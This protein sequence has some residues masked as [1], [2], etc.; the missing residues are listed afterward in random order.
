M[1]G[2]ARKVII[3]AAVDGLIL[4]PLNSKKE[5]RVAPPV[6]IKYGDAAISN[7][8]SLPDTSKGTSSFEAFGIIGK[9]TLKYLAAASKSTSSQVSSPSLSSATSFR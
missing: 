7:I 3:Y 4:Q 1:P 8:S 2:L 9:S 6:K 5:Q